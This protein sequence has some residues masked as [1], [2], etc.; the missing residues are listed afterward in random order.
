MPAVT[1]TSAAWD[2]DAEAIRS[3]RE[4]VFVREQGIPLD[5][6]FDGTDSVCMHVLAFAGEHPVGTGRIT[7]T[8]HI[9]RVAVLKEYRGSGVGSAIIAALTEHAARRGLQ[10]VYLNSQ[11]SSA[12]FY[13]AL[14]FVPTGDIF[15]EADI[16]HIRMTRPT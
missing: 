15:I 12:G 16:E 9:G 8:G 1:I 7:A 10:C 3:V 5:I 13:E 6:D 14:G 4:S 2:K 11:K